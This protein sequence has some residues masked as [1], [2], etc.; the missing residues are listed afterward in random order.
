MNPTDYYDDLASTYDADRFGNSY[1]RFL[2]SRERAVLQA[3]LE[4]VPPADV[5]DLGCGTGRMLGFAGT[6]VDGSA[7]MLEQARARWP[8][9]RL[10]HAPVTETGLDD[11][12]YAAVTCLHVLMHLDEATVRATFAEAARVVRPGGRF[13]V[14]IPSAPRRAWGRRRAHGWHGDTAASI[15]TLRT[16]AGDAWTLRRWH[17]L[18][19][20]PLHRIPVGMRSAVA[21]LDR[22]LGTSPIA[23]W[24]SYYLCEFVRP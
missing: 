11:G 1:G 23:P 10:V 7:R 6:G 5:A 22:W 13:L 3:W 8:D 18:L 14:D 20:L 24:A 21:P 15:E 17:G 19:A 16:W 9:R 4:G 12:T 2:D